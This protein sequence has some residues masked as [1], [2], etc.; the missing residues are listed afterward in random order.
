MDR[1]TAAAREGTDD[2]R[3][4]DGALEE[5]LHL[6]QQIESSMEKALEA[7]EFHAWYQ[8]K[9]DI[10]TKRVIGAEAL[11][12]WISHDMGFMPP[13]KFIPLFET[14]GFVIPVD[15]CLLEQAFALQKERLAAGKEVVPISVNQSRL[16]ITEEGYLDKMKAIVD[17]Y[18]LPKGLI[19]LELTETVFG[20]FDQLGAQRQ[21]ADIVHALHDMGFSISVDDFGSG[22]SSFTMLNFLP[23][24]VMKIDRSLLVATD[25]SQRM[26]NIL[27][28]VI[29]LGK[30]LR[31]QI[32]CEGIETKE[33]E[34][35]LLELGCRMGQGYI[36]SKP[37]P[38]DD[39]E[40]FLD[41]KNA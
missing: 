14:N 36:F 35:L 19:E 13:G 2:V 41:A 25:D 29:R 15:Y 18:R 31:M 5:Q 33:Q 20:D 27:G 4:F 7:G 30:T 3:I 6:Q 22:Y 28:N 23:L 26:R 21:A 1:A 34:D 32:I 24:D 11:V 37:L 12:R 17:K 8:P 10:E 40:K 38:K 16:H 39:F 9:Y